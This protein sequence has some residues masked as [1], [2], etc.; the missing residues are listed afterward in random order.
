MFSYIL[1]AFQPHGSHILDILPKGM[2]RRLVGRTTI[3]T[4]SESV[5]SEIAQVAISLRDRIQHP[6]FKCVGF[7]M[8]INLRWHDKETSSVKSESMSPSRNENLKDFL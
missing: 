1:Y 8:D 3:S 5:Y 6:R 4:I 7:E 2:K